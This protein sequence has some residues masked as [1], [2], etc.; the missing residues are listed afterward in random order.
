MNS[1]L[2][3]LEYLRVGLFWVGIALLVILALA[4]AYRVVSAA[5]WAKAT[6]NFYPDNKP[7][8]LSKDRVTFFYNRVPVERIQESDPYEVTP[9]YL[10]GKN[11]GNVLLY[12]VKFTDQGGGVV[13]LVM[14]R[15]QFERMLQTFGESIMNPRVENVYAIGHVKILRGNTDYCGQQVLLQGNYIQFGQGALFKILVADVLRLMQEHLHP[16]YL[17]AM[18]QWQVQALR[19]STVV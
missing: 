15:I 19:T 10:F 14:G 7:G 3:F 18:K 9:V 16:Q 5:A 8:T 17:L 2:F 1:F 4:W 13:K 11:T 12:R 6:M